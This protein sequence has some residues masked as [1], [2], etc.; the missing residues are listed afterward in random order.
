M[1]DADHLRIVFRVN[2]VDFV[3]PVADL[4]AIRG[5]DEDEVS[6]LAQ[7]S[8]SL[9]LGTLVYRDADVKVY[10]LAALFCL[11]AVEPVGETMLLLFAGSDYPWA[12]RVAYV[13][14]VVDAAKFEFVDLPAYFFRDGFV[15]YHQVALYN[16]KLLVSINA[17]Q[18]DVAW[19]RC[20]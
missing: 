1:V 15:P 11:T 5:G 6:P 17:R 2:G 10:D 12:V 7:L 3:M 16:D 4:L 9:Q 13:S 14:G 8:G 20:G 18:I 19:R